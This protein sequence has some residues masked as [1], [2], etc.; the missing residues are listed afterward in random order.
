MRSTRKTSIFNCPNC[1]A[2][3]QVV[4]GEPGHE[5]IDRSVACGSCRGPLPARDGKFVLKYFLLRN[6]I[7]K[8]K[9]QRRSPPVARR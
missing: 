9:W 5:T 2:L 3:Y 7:R 1:D 6:A 8:Q 4:K